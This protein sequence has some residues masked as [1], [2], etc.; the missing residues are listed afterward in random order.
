MA[1]IRKEQHMR[2]VTPTKMLSSSLLAALALVLAAPAGAAPILDGDDLG[3]AP[4]RAIP[5][6]VQPILAS[7]RGA[8]AP[9]AFE[10]AVARAPVG[11]RQTWNDR[12]GPGAA[13]PVLRGRAGLAA[14]QATGAQL[15]WNDHY[16]P[17]SA[18]PIVSGDTGVATRTTGD[19][20]PAWN[21]HYGP[22][23]AGPIV[24]EDTGVAARTTGDQQPAWLRALIAR[25]K[26]MNEFYARPTATSQPSYGPMSP[27]DRPAGLRELE[28]PS[29]SAGAAAPTRPDDR[30]VHR[31][32]S[33]AP[34]LAVGSADDESDWNGLGIAMLGGVGVGFLVVGGSLLV[35]H[36]RRR[37]G[38]VALP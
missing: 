7:E 12:Y 9:D 32:V 38:R 4:A 17:G 30:A 2:P 33:R 23:S 18:G 29:A 13:G 14:R 15:A 21:D 36:H 11:M 1:A 31:P 16:G 22:G 26:A 8:V 37:D 35:V 28:A 19:Q 24:S 3:D 5:E 25:S 27:A 20:Q 10:R 34:F 6:P